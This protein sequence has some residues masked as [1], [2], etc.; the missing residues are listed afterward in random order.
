MFTLVLAERKLSSEEI[1]R[2]GELYKVN[3]PVPKKEVDTKLIH[4]GLVLYCSLID[5]K[6]VALNDLDGSHPFYHKDGSIK[7]VWTDRR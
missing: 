2:M 4:T 7:E 6:V 3:T 1:E 5:N